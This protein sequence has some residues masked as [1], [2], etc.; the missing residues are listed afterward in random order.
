MF[1]LSV[2][3][4]SSMQLTMT[5][6]RSLMPTTFSDPCSHSG[7]GEEWVRGLGGGW[8]DGSCMKLTFKLDASG[9]P[10]CKWHIPRKESIIAVN[11]RLF[12]T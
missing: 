10:T 3:L 6:R 4:A 11:D 12:I 2:S 9:N 5:I 7:E 8:E 1:D